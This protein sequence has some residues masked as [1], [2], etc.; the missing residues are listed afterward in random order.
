MVDPWRVAQI[1]VDRG[2]GHDG[3]RGS[4][5]L[6]APG[7]VLTAAHVVAGASVVR[8]RLDVGQDTEIDVQAESWWAD[9]AGH[10]GTDLAVITIPE[11]ATAGR[12]FEPARFGR[13]S[14]CAAVLIGG[15]VRLPALQAPGR[16]CR[17][18]ATRGC[19]GLRAG[20]RSRAG[21]GE[22]PSGHPGRLPGRPSPRQPP[23]GEPSPWEGMSGGPVLAGGR[24][25]GV[26]AEH[27]PSEGTG[28]LT[29]RRIDRAY[30]ELSASDLGRLVELLGL[31][32]AASGLP[33]VVPR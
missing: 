17:R 5:Y 4:G 29:A 19:S 2:P 23:E 1:A 11:T 20:G 26:V 21:G 10:H 14:D 24:I 3:S 31:P 22:P 16:P 9:P 13:I 33:D 12:A 6:I 32:P 28:R 30:E 15:R 25:V 18:S 8:V 27:H 7:R